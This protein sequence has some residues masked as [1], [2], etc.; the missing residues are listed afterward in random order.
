[1]IH[2]H[3]LHLITY[4]TGEHTMRTINEILRES[5]RIQKKLNRMKIKENFGQKEIRAYEDFIGYVGDY[6]MKTRKTIEDILMDIRVYCENKS[7]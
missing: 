3:T 1:M 7:Y 6:D 5:V 2:L 4:T